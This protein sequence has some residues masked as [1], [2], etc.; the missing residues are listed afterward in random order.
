MNKN[1]RPKN[2]NFP[3][4]DEFLTEFKR[5]NL[6]M[7]RI[8]G[9]NVHFGFW[10]HPQGVAGT[11]SDFIAAS[12]RMNEVLINKAHIRAGAKI[13]DVGCGFGGT[14]QQINRAFDRLYL[15]G[16][17]IDPRQLKR[18]RA[19]VKPKGTNE[20]KFVH[21]DACQ[22]PFPDQSF[23]IL[24]AIECA[25][26]FRSRAAFL[27]EAK[28]VLKKNGKLIISDFVFFLPTQ[29][30]FQVWMNHSSALKTWG[31]LKTTS[32]LAYYSKLLAQGFQN[33][34]FENITPFTKPNYNLLFNT[35]QGSKALKGGLLFEAINRL[36]LVKYVIIEAESTQRTETHPSYG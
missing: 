28:R 11:S 13:L 23:D 1:S 20:I 36:N 25:F 26:H 22:L 15:C 14:L 5:G 34:S 7:E 21:G 16:L 3:Y 27:A 8:W 32:E 30:L 19:K 17:N 18:A 4:I 10:D 9:S 35:H 6:D 29:L 33:V 2:F 31:P 12:K 24:F